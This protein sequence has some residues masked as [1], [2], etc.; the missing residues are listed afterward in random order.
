MNLLIINY[1]LEY[2]F[3][4]INE[5]FIKSNNYEELIPKTDNKGII[6]WGHHTIRYAV[7]KY[8]II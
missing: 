4:K 3:N 2:N 5:L 7:F 6:D 8:N 1:S